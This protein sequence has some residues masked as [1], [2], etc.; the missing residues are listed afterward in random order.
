MGQTLRKRRN[1]RILKKVEEEESL[2]RI[3]AISNLTKNT[4]Q[5]V[6]KRK[7]CVYDFEITFEPGG[8]HTLCMTYIGERFTFNLRPAERFEDRWRFRIH[9]D[10][11]QIC[12][13]Y[14]NSFCNNHIDLIIRHL[15]NLFDIAHIETV[16]FHDP[17]GDIQNLCNIS[18]IVNST[19]MV[20]SKLTVTK[21]E[22]DL[23]KLKFH[24]LNFMNFVTTAPAGYEGFPLA[25][26]TAVIQNDTMLSWA[27]LSYSQSTYIKVHGSNVTSS[28]LNQFLKS[29]IRDRAPKN[30]EFM[31]FED[32][33]GTKEE[34]F[35]GI[36][37]STENLKLTGSFR[38]DQV[39]GSEFWK[40]AGSVYIERDDYLYA[41]ISFQFGRTVIFAV[42]TYEK[43]FGED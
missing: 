18:E 26:K 2:F 42:W 40:R 32:F 24:R 7:L 31:V 37:T 22:L 17:K 3:I 25:Y 16:K 19:G 28:G 39:F 33:I 13:Y 30:L 41:T 12:D 14:Y 1:E 38:K 6:K 5:I 20:I 15:M 35:K 36:K 27:H 23:I 4:H 11:R 43:L 9:K 8:K 34:I 10:D 21:E 29:W